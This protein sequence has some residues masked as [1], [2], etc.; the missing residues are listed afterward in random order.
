M[1][2]HAVLGGT[3]DHLHTGHGALLIHAFSVASRVTIGLTTDDYVKQNKCEDENI[4]GVVCPCVSS[5]RTQSFAVRKEQLETWLHDHGVFD[6]A[7]IVPIND[8]F[9]PTISK[10]NQSRSMDIIVVTTNTKNGALTVN[11]KRKTLGLLPLVIA[12]IPL[13]NAE[14]TKPISA[15]RIR[16]QEIDTA[17]RL[18]MPDAMRR[19]LSEPFGTVLRD[20]NTESVIRGDHEAVVISVGDKTTK[21]LLDNGLVPT[22]AIIDMQVERQ[23][24]VWEKEYWDKLPD[25]KKEFIS[26]PGYISSSI[27][28]AIRSWAHDT[29]P[30][31]FVID[32]EEDLL[33]LPVILYAP[34]GSI[35][36]YGQPNVGLVRIMVTDVAK[37]RAHNLLH[38]F[39]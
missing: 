38:Q 3:F 35:V 19:E 39:T 10:N 14:D 8:V 27:V 20:G 33:V 26:G 17:G 34:H 36:Y 37:R 7:T 13:V 25:N 30:S 22:L 24:Y 1:Y 9:G 16:N 5:S 18:V 28:D 6:R 31:F 4:S 23:P 12:I 29:L 21:R 2:K 32:G 11:K 15:T